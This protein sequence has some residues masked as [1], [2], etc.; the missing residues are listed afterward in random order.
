MG[1]SEDSAGSKT[2][3]GHDVLV[4]VTELVPAIRARAC[5]TER[6]RR[7]HADN[8][9]DLA[10]AGVFR[11]RIPADVGGYE[12]DDVIV[13]EVLALPTLLADEVADEIYTT[14]DVRITGPLAPDGWATPDAG[15]YRLSGQWQWN[16]VDV[17]SDWFAVGCMTASE[18]PVHKV[19]LVPVSH[20]VQLDGWHAAGL[21]GSASNGLR[22]DDVFVPASRTV[23]MKEMNEGVFTARRYSANPYFNRPWIMVASFNGGAAMVGM[24]RGAMDVFMEVLPTRGPITF[25]GWTKAADAP[26][27]HHQLARAQLDLDAAEH[28]QTKLLSQL[29]AALQTKMTIPDRVQSRA[30]FGEIT[31][32]ACD[33]ATGLFRA[34]GASQVV[35]SA[36]IQR[37]HRDISVAAQNAHLQPS[38]TTELFGRIL[39]GLAPD[40]DFL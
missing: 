36:D 22:I 26:V 12:A 33:C 2:V 24:A 38:S 4:R 13:A 14:P 10:N 23:P 32:L 35:F 16:S 28:F 17:H 8:L 15:G 25:I 9:T 18:D 3:S 40:T 31:R 5:D 37:Y 29:Q 6:L 20:V 21:A 7:M 34:G 1:I 27:L 30:W 39:A 11:L 19:A